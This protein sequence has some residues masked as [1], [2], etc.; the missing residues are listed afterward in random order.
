[1]VDGVVVVEPPAELDL[2][3]TDALVRAVSAAVVTGETV[4]LHLDAER[5]P[6]PDRWPHP[7]SGPDPAPQD[8]D[9]FTMPIGPG[10]VRL[11]TGHETWT[12]D[13][14]R[15][16]FCRS[17]HPVDP[18]FVEAPSWTAIRAVWI[19]ADRTA[20]LTTAGT[21]VSAPSAWSRSAAGV[22]AA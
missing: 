22:V 14:A 5:A 12:L 18:R 6:D 1:M 10:F 15:R 9:R 19:T 21:Y 7:A 2:D 20:V 8:L 17:A 13:L 4:M 11:S 3:A 16:R